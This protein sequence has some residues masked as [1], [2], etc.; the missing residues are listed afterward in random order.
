MRS[1]IIIFLLTTGIYLSAILYNFRKKKTKPEQIRRES[2]SKPEL[3][4]ESKIIINVVDASEEIDIGKYADIVINI[5]QYIN[6]QEKQEH[7]KRL[8]I[9]DINFEKYIN[10]KI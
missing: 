3:I 9:K 5:D 7:I 6:S 10:I 8:F 4:A 2:I 1:E